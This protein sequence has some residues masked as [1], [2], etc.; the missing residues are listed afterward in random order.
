MSDRAIARQSLLTRAILAASGAVGLIARPWRGLNLPMRVMYG[1]GDMRS[2]LRNAEQPD[3]LPAVIGAVSLLADALVGLDWAVVRKGSPQQGTEVVSNIAAAH[4]LATWP[5][6]ARWAFI[7]SA[8]IAGNG[9]AHIVDDGRGAP[10]RIVTYP[11]GRV[12]FRLWE[13]SRLSLLL[14]PPTSGEP[15]EVDDSACAI[16]RYRPTSYDERIGISPLAQASETIELLLRNRRM[17]SSTMHN[18]ARPSGYLKTDKPLDPQ[19]AEMLRQRWQALYAGDGVGGTA[20]LE[21]GLEY[22]QLSL[23]D[24]QQLSAI[25]TARMGV[26]DIARL[27]NVPVALMLG[28]EQARATASEDRRRLISFAVAPL[29][30]LIED[31]LSGALLTREQR[32]AGYAVHLDTSIE[33]LGQGAEMATAISGLLNAGAVTVSEVRAR[34]GMSAVQH[35]DVLRAPTNTWP[36]DAWINAAP[37]SQNDDASYDPAASGTISSEAPQRRALSFYKRRMLQ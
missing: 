13:N 18:A 27:F 6:H 5:L 4:A 14:V 26:G 2:L 21:Q 11:S 9:V 7:Y 3:S 25:E 15:L 16:L 33:Q 30:R 10:Q 23:S 37:R 31:A 32:A 24:L 36:L 8:L 17:V 35:G 19:K 12:S 20:V 28:T 34:L 1:P 22:I 29:A